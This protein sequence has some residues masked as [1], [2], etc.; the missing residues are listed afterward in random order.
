MNILARFDI[1]ALE[2]MGAE[3]VQPEA[4]ATRLAFDARDRFLADADSTTL[5]AHRPDPQTAARLAARIDA[6]RAHARVARRTEAIHRDTVTLT[7]VDRDRMA[8]SLIYSTYHSFGA[9]LASR[10][11]GS[12][13]HN[14]GTGFTLEPGHPTVAAGGKRPMLTIIPGMVRQGGR[15]VASF[16]VMGGADQTSG[17]ARLLSN[18]VDFGMDPQQA[19]DAPRAFAGLFSLAARGHAVRWSGRMLSCWIPRAC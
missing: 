17:H 16:G 11:F 7:V 1:A 12:A 13:F 19:I 4:E 15:V 9:R 2:P 8:V 5:L 3:R 14:R 18:M 10:G 6:G